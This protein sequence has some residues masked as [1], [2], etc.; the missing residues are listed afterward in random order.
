MDLDGSN[1]EIFARGVR[2]TVGFTWHPETGEMWFTDNGRD[3][4]GDNYPPCE[5]NR[6]SKPNE[7][8]GYPYCHGGN[9]S[10]PEFGSKYPCD[11][12][13][14]PVQNLGPHVAPLGVKFYNGNMFPELNDHLLIG[15][16]KFKQIHAIKILNDHP[17]LER[18]LLSKS[19]GRIREMYKK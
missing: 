9:I 16:L 15:S 17:V 6:I 13:I 5:L 3:M 19:Y 7:H 10:D 2:N 18:K 8:Y 4:L 12:F 1:R 14:K 11:D